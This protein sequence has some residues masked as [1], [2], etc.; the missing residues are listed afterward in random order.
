M[1]GLFQFTLAAA[2]LQLGAVRPACLP[3]PSSR[4]CSPC[5]PSPADDPAKRNSASE[6][7]CCLVTVYRERGTTSADKPFARPAKELD[8]TAAPLSNFGGLGSV[9]RISLSPLA[10][11]FKSPPL[12]LLRQTCLLRI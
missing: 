12:D 5:C 10:A 4:P 7:A 2:M 6:P 8:R 11:N 3:Q 1:R 9:S